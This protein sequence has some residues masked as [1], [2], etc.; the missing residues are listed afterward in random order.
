MIEPDQ[1]RASL[2]GMGLRLPVVARTDQEAPARPLPGGVLQLAGVEDVDLR[3]PGAVG[4]RPDQ[5]AAAFVRIRAGR[6]AMNR[7][8]RRRA[9]RHSASPLQSRSDR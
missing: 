1:L 2:T 4:A 6:V 7:L 3:R 8:E 5:R 9:D